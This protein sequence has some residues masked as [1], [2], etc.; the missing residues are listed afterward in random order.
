MPRTVLPLR[1]TW[2]RIVLVIV[3][4]AFLGFTA[5]LA[6]GSP[7]PPAAA[8][9]VSGV[10]VATPSS[11]PPPPPA[12][13]TLLNEST[14]VLFNNT[15]VPG[16]DVS[17]SSSL[18][19]IEVYDPQNNEVFV[20]GFYSGVIDG[21][22]TQTNEVVST[23]T[24]GAYP[25]TLAYDATTNGLFFGLQTDDEVSLA[26]ASTGLVQ[27]TVGIG[28]EPL[29]MAVDPVSGNLFVTGWNS[30]GTAYIA[31]LS[32]ST[33]VVDATFAFGMDRF[34]VAGP[35]GLAYDPANG[36]F[37]IASI[38]GGATGTRGNLTVVNAS[39][40]STLTNLSL[41]FNPDAIL[42]AP[43]TGN[44][45]LGNQS[46]DDL[47]VFSPASA[48]VTGT[49]L[50]PNVPSLLTYGSTHKRVYVGIDGNVSVVNTLTNKVTSTFP[51]TRQ[52]DGLAFDAH[53]GELFISDYVWN[54]VSV[55]NTSSFTVA[56]SILLGALPYN[57]A[58]DSGNGDLYVAD[59]E[60]S[61]LIVVNAA[62]E[63]V[64]GYIPLGTTPYGVVYDPMTQDV[65][66]DDFYTGN[67]SVV[68]CATNTLV[69]YLPAGVNPWGIAY[70]GAN[71]DIYVTNVGSN[72]ITILNPALRTV[73]RSLNFTTPPGAIAYDPRSSTLFVGEY[74][75]G[76]I[77]VL[78]ATSNKL[79]RNTTT[80]SE[81]YTI[82]IDPGTGH[83]FVGNY[84]S[85]NV[86]VLGPRG[87]ELGRSVAVGV[88]VFGSAYNPVDGNLYVVSFTSDL[89]SV[90]NSTSATGVGGYPVGSGPVAVAVDPATGSIFVANYDSGSLTVLTRPVVLP[91]FNV[92]FS[93][94][95]LP[96]GKRW[97]VAFDGVLQNTT[98]TMVTFTATNGSYTY[99][100]TG[101]SEFEVSGIPSE[102]TI[103]VNGASLIESVL[104]VRGTTYT[105]TFHET[106]LPTV[107]S[108]CVE[109][110]SKVCTT[111]ADLAFKN[112]TNGTYAFSVVP[113]SGYTAKPSS[114][115]LT[116]AGS[117]FREKISF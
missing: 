116:L 91:T 20:E 113:I 70:D 46:G 19:S 18:P 48:S 72:N 26:N 81:P 1:S 84:A 110:G 15:L 103:P 40:F 47:G 86:T 93:E 14:L 4:G 53:N 66:V 78:N 88:G 115:S 29:A 77:S 90:I 63:H 32:G 83:A 80:G 2:G 17:V 59:L 36:D 25:N 45:Y 6:A 30:T 76:N 101:P 97:S 28:F 114:G 54:N 99:L 49:V 67:V 35:N 73:V 112:L 13:P 37:Y 109:F 71:H 43:S 111:A 100:V 58:Y 107:T 21:L 104:F 61:Q 102:G 75:V 62:T 60:S 95:G 3:V 105:I 10:S 82:S 51:V 64:T 57:M 9:T 24:T 65:Y 98:S 68:S 96:H 108:W 27:R 94:T 41:T 74:N 8:P 52:P 69:G 89:L 92:T 11:V 16:Y 33:G 5:P 31:V 56:G 79:I 23:I 50:L 38:V 44:L 39:S 22:N 55:V 12:S 85:D 87:Q 7:A 34:P 117:G 106:G 42:Y